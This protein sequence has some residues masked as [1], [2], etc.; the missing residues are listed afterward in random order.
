M[1]DEQIRQQ[2]AREGNEPWHWLGPYVSDRQWGT[3]REDY[4]PDGQPWAYTTHD[5]ARS[6]AYRWGEEAIGGVC[7]EQ[8][9]LCLA[10]A[11][12]NGQDPILKE[13]LF[14]LSNPEGNHGEDVKELYYYLDS[15]PTH[16]YMQMLYKYPQHAFPYDWLVRE[17]SRRG[18][19]KPE[20]E[21][22]DTCVFRESRYFDIFIEYAK[23]GPQD[24][25]MQITVHNRGPQ[26]AP[27]HVL[28][29]LWFRNTWRWAPGSYRPSLGVAEGG[30]ICVDHAR[31]PELQLYCE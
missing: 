12:W 30:H 18:R 23:A 9:L 24:L 17:N 19:R 4:S 22:Q 25:L 8:Q 13:R 1:N 15:T 16:S 21:L 2:Q 3:V 26:E 28:P 20:F 29:Q 14:G 31:L 11:F 10:P 5:M 27:L 6:L 7:D